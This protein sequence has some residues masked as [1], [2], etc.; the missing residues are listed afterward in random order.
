MSSPNNSSLLTPIEVWPWTSFHSPSSRRN[1]PVLRKG[2]GV[3]SGSRNEALRSITQPTLKSG[4]RAP[5]KR[6]DPRSHERCQGTLELLEA[7]EPFYRAK[8]LRGEPLR[9]EP[10][11]G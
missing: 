11:T 6:G 1:T 4:K 7:E 3:L 5:R 2:I 9:S 8:P 10:R